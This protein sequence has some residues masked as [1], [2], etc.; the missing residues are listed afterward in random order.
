MTIQEVL[1]EMRSFARMMGEPVPQWADDI[2]AAMRERDAEI[3]RLKNWQ[4]VATAPDDT[5]VLVLWGSNAAGPEG[6]EIAERRD[7]GYWITHGGERID[8][9][10]YRVLGW[11]PLPE[12]TTVLA[13]KEDV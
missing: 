4:P 3:E 6:I 2:E 1:R 10:G 8:A 5:Y 7:D 13:G 11:I 9:D 12:K